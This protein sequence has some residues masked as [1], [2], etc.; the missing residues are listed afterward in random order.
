MQ[1]FKQVAFLWSC[2]KVTS[3][4][5]DQ[6][7]IIPMSLRFTKK[8][9]G[10]LSLLWCFINDDIK[11]KQIRGMRWDQI[12]HREAKR[13]IKAHGSVLNVWKYFSWVNIAAAYASKKHIQHSN[14]EKSAVLLIS[15]GSHNWHNQVL[16][17]YSSLMDTDETL[18]IKKFCFCQKIDNFIVKKMYPK[19]QVALDWVK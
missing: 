17:V 12:R 10:N 8:Q 16:I 2:D 7:L 14:E 13:K 15:Y 9:N 4:K 6:F 3:I 5:T 1:G 11:W 19:Q 18:T